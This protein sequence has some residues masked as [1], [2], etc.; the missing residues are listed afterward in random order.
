LSSFIFPDIFMS[1]G[2]IV[3]SVIGAFT[4]FI[5]AYK[6]VNLGL[7]ILISVISIYLISLFV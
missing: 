1:T 6:K 3:T 7:N 2:N 4:A 5:L